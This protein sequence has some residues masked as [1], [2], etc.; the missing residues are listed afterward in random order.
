MIDDILAAIADIFDSDS[1]LMFV[2][3]LALG[4][5]AIGLIVPH[6]L[7]SRLA[8][9][10]RMAADAKDGDA[11]VKA[12]NPA[13][14]G[15]RERLES[16]V[17]GLAETAGQGDQS[18]TR[19][20]RTKLIQ[21]GYYDKRAVVWFFGMRLAGALLFAAVATLA[22]LAV[23]PESGWTEISIF[24][25]VGL[26]L[27]FV[28]PS[29]VLDRRIDKL[30]QEHS[31]GFP[32]FMDLMVVCAQAGLSMEAAINRIARE[33]GVAFPSLA[34]NLEFTAREIR[35]GKPLAKAIES[36]AVRLGIAEASSF[37]TLLQQSEELG[38]SLTQSLRTYS[39]DMRN[40][41][42]MKAEEKAYALPAKLVVPLTLFVFPVLLVVLML[43]VVVSFSS[44][45]L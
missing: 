38:S 11:P 2:V 42:L 24:A 19:V 23:A 27:G 20:L 37:S 17:G 10:R 34:R 30:K 28:A 44:A 45:N 22:T 25:L 33:I 4:A 43:P 35:S 41:R 6:L 15:A 12:A 5:S 40:K 1:T 39:D 21:A 14:G 9:Q 26:G 13:A 8:V 36:L 7:K 3:A 29:I 18:Q 16:F 32:D 31:G